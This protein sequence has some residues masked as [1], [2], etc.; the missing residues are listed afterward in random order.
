M[1]EAS[2]FRPVFR[3]AD[4]TSAVSVP[5]S[6]EHTSLLFGLVLVLSLKSL[7]DKRRSSFFIFGR[8]CSIVISRMLKVQIKRSR[9]WSKNNCTEL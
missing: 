2:L 3:N 7:C 8:T 4:E 9:V 5:G 1:G 6:T